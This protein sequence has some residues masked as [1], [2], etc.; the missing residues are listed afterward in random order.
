MSEEIAVVPDEVLAVGRFA[1]EVATGL[2]SSADV[3]N[4]EVEA[5]LLSWKGK[6]AESYS[7]GWRE[8][9]DSARSVWDELFELAGKLGATAD[10]FRAQESGSA[11][12]FTFLDI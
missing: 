7:A 8:M 10:T 11:G 12:E 5:L 9:R 1:Y 2:R 6:S 4:S 3:L